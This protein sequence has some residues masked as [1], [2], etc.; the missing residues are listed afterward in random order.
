MIADDGSAMRM[1]ELQQVSA[2]ENLPITTIELLIEWLNER[3]G[4]AAGDAERAAD[5]TAAA[6]GTAAAAG[7]A[8]DAAA[9]GTAAGAASADL[10]AEPGAAADAAALGTAAGAAAADL[11]AEP[12]TSADVHR[13]SEPRVQFEV[14]T[15]VPT[16]HGPLRMR[17]YR[18][19]KTGT[20]HIAIIAD[21]P[22]SG[23]PAGGAPGGAPT[24]GAPGSAPASDVPTGRT[25]EPTPPPLVRVHSECLTGEAFGSLKCECGPQL[26]TSLDLIAEHGGVVVYLRGHEGRG[27]GLVNKLRAYCLQEDGLDTFDANVALGL[28]ADARD[29]GA[30]VAMLDDLG[31][32]S[33]RLLTNNPEKVRQLEEQG[34]T[35]TERVPLVVGATAQNQQ[36]LDTKRDRM[37]HLLPTSAV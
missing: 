26:D 36:Y 8:A 19:L 12:G 11:V 37:G 33:I 20:D 21:P 17:A 29:Y 10:V 2:R 25:S 1:D 22:G 31:A 6:P 24:G 4:I 3:D 14:E 34:I 16:T 7:T 28:P 18:D 5:P 23:L 30:A 15:T 9:P 27:I 32:S 35:V 13:A